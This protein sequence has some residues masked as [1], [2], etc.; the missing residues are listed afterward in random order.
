MF[1]LFA[2]TVRKILI[3]TPIFNPLN[4]YSAI[5]SFESK[6][7]YFFDL[8]LADSK[9]N[10]TLFWLPNSIWIEIMR[11]I[12]FSFYS[13]WLQTSDSIIIFLKS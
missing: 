6:Y 3:T 8:N 5:I 12:P 1:L 9:E 4:C 11:I 13:F 10:Y 7:F 2:S